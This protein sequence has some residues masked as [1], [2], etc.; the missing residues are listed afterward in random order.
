MKSKWR[1]FEIRPT[2][3]DESFFVDNEFEV[4][5]TEFVTT[6]PASRFEIQNSL[7]IILIYYE[8]CLYSNNGIK[9]QTYRNLA[10]RTHV[11]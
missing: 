6:D 9:S 1:Y 11:L 4:R 5:F 8:T 2:D 3:I 7:Q 10:F